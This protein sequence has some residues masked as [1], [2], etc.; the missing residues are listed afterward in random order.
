[1]TLQ[2]LHSFGKEGTELIKLTDFLG[3]VCD[4]FPPSTSMLKNNKNGRGSCNHNQLQR[5]NI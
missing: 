3:E 1:M 4:Y 2:A 5:S